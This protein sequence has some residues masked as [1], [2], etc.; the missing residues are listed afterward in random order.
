MPDGADAHAVVRLQ[1]AVH[2]GGLPVPE[3]EAAVAVPADH[4][5]HVRR[6]AHLARVAGG[7]V[8]CEELL[9]VQLEPVARRVHQNLVIQ[10]LAEEVLGVPVVAGRR[11]HRGHRMHPGLS[12]VLHGCRPN[13]ILPYEQLLV[14]TRSDDAAVVV[15][16][17]ARVDAPEMLDVLLHERLLLL[18]PRVPLEEVLVGAADEDVVVARVDLAAEG[19]PLGLP[20]LDLLARFR[21]PVPHRLV[22]SARDDLATILREADVAYGLRVPHVRAHAL[23]AVV[24]VPDLDLAIH[25]RGQQKVPCLRKPLD[26]MHP[27][28]VAGPGVDALFRDVR[29]PVALFVLRGRIHPRAPLVVGLLLAVEGRRAF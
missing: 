10:R 17:G 8:A 26:R 12:D 24:D 6:D 7:D 13:A 18:D 21:V 15:D 4:V 19:D 11:G 23:A 1:L 22:I 20:A 3:P 9:L 16:E 5:L 14:V 28:G 25:R 27:L 2:L 29:G